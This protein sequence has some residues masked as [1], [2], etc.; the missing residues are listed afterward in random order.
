MCNKRPALQ[1]GK[2]TTGDNEVRLRVFLLPELGSE[3]S[4]LD[5]AALPELN[6]EVNHEL[7]LIIFTQFQFSHSK[8]IR[9]K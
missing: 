7:F 3:C 1:S 6:C 9:P 4:L 2:L 8:I 5:N